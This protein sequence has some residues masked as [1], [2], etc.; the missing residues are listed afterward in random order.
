MTS[1][2]KSREELEAECD[3][4]VALANEEAS[5]RDGKIES[6]QQQIQD[7]INKQKLIEKK[8][9]TSVS[10][11]KMYLAVHDEVHQSSIR[12]LLFSFR[13]TWQCER[14]WIL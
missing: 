4:K 11:L 12:V 6:L 7:E 14:N 5:K 10:S 2:L 13:K 9:H 8:G 1:E 3:R